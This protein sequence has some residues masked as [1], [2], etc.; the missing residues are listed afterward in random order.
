M[1]KLI[2]IVLVLGGLLF[3]LSFS[4]NILSP[5]S[6]GRFEKMEPFSPEQL[7]FIPSTGHLYIAEATAGRIDIFDPVDG[8]L[9]YGTVN[10]PNPSG[11]VEWNKQ[12]LVTSFYDGQ[13]FVHILDPESGE[14]IERF[15]A[16]PGARSPVVIENQQLLA[17]CHS[18]KG[19][20]GIYNLKNGKLTKTIPVLRQPNISV[21]S[22]DQNYLFVANF[23]THQ[24]ADQDTVASAVSVI[25]LQTME[26]E[27]NLLLANGSNA[28]RGMAVSS[29]GKYVYVSHNLGRFQ[30][31]TTQL[32]QGWMNT[33]ALSIIRIKDLSYAGTLL[34]DEPDFGA[35]GS[36]GVAATDGRLVVAHS[37]THD[38]SIIDE[39][40][41]LRKLEQS[42]NRSALS[43]DLNF[44]GDVRIRVKL[45]G[46]GPRSVCLV[47]DRLYTAMYFSDTI[48]QLDLSTSGYPIESY[49]L[50]QGF[51]ESMSRLGE[52]YFHDASYCFQGWQ[53]CTGCHPMDARTD[54]LNWDLLNDGIGNP[55]NCKSLLLSHQTPP[56]MITGIRAD[57]ETA[58]RAGFKYIQFTSVPE[59]HAVAVDAYLSG[60]EP[61]ASPF[62]VNGKLSQKARKGKKVFN[63]L[64]CRQC[65]AE[66]WY[67]D[68]KMHTFTSPMDSLGE[69]AWDTPT[70]VEV[71]RT[72]PWLHDGRC[73][74]MKEVF[75]LDR[76]GLD[77]E[78]SKNELE[79]LVEYVLSL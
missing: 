6:D 77:R 69:Q 27:K 34:L 28:L 63:E 55:K 75:Q 12:L 9:T 19:E 68:G 52:K 20:V 10:I 64:G 29:D 30:I 74:S 51:T 76:H 23:L 15:K 62:L 45:P 53:A 65:H 43:Y 21:L 16:G 13:G 70:L 5:G 14:K 26:V 31:P 4:G 24:R 32:E 41:M 50:N 60:L 59:S 35:A 1:K 79:E 36:W 38:V 61:E 48:N 42:S 39:E 25:N 56:A 72:G 17:V 73:A 3:S 67:A 22:P 37:G 7:L 47:N 71:W 8:H 58:V 54:G 18:W 2:L 44:L 66:P 33:S 46:N 78:L 49:P 57:A 40:A 11:M